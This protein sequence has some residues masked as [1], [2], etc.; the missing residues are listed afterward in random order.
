MH[1]QKF[2]P[3]KVSNLYFCIFVPEIELTQ[4]NLLMLRG[5]LLEGFYF[6]SVFFLFLT[7][8]SIQYLF[9]DPLG[10]SVGTDHFV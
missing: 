6:L 4:N 10:E 1:A 8:V 7:V 5:E 2:V 9:S 3:Q